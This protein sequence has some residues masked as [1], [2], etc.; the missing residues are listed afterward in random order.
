MS[1]QIQILQISFR[2]LEEFGSWILVMFSPFIH[3]FS[4]DTLA[5]L[6]CISLLKIAQ[7]NEIVKIISVFIAMNITVLFCLSLTQCEL[8]SYFNL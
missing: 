7:F 2:T 5:T 8:F 4:F 6:Y 3:S 1:F